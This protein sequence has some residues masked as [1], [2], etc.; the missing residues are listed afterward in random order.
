MLWNKRQ[1][2]ENIR[3]REGK[4]V[5][6]LGKGD[7]PGRIHFPEKEHQRDGDNAGRNHDHQKRQC[8]INAEAGEQDHNAHSTDHGQ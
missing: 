5:F 6:Y 7:I 8:R 1:V 2:L 3:N 4:R